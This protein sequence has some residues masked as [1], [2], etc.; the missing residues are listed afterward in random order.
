MAGEPMTERFTDFTPQKKERF[1]SELCKMPNVSRA[2]RLAKIS[3][4]TAYNHRDSDPDFKQAWD[5]AL[6]E[7][8]ESLE[9]KA[10]Q[11]A[12][13]GSDTL[14]IF[15]LKAHKPAKYNLPTRQEHSGRDGGA[16]QTQSTVDLSGLSIEQLRAF[17]DALKD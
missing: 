9:E 13:K 5:D 10:W 4:P 11:Q 6:E 17:A 8:I 2:C 16:I 1:L 14:T 3:R 7:G 12:K 15:L